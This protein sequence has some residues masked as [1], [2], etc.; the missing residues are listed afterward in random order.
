LWLCVVLLV[1][2]RAVLAQQT[3]SLSGIVTAT[4]GSVLPGVTVEAR[5]DVLPTPRVTVTG[6]QGE[7]RLPALPPGLYTLDFTLSG[8][9]KSSRQAQVQLGINTVIDTTLGVAGVSEQVTVTAETSLVNRTAPT[10]QNALTSAQFRQMPVGQEY[11][12]LIKM[13]P[14]VQYTEDLVR[15]PSA[16]GSGQDNVYQFDGANVTLPLFGTL[17]AEPSSHDIAQITSTQGGARA[18]NFDRAGG[19]SVDSVSKSGTNRYTGQIGIQFQNEAMSASL[20]SGIASRFEQ[21]RSWTDMSFGGPLI[22]DN[23]FFYASYYRPTSNRNDRTN[24][25]GPLPDYD[26]S[27]N[28]G[29]VKFTLTPRSDT[30]INFSYRGSDRDDNTNERFDSNVGPETGSRTEVGLRIVTL[31]GSWVANARSFA[32]FKYSH[33][34]NDNFSEPAFLATQTSSSTIGTQLDVNNLDTVGQLT[35]PQPVANNA[36]YNAFVQPFIDRYG[37]LTNGVPTG[38]GKVGYGTQFDRDDFFRD[39]IQFG[40]NYTLG[41]TISHELHAGYQWYEDSEDLERTSNGWGTITIPGGR[42]SAIAGTGQSPFF[43]TR[44]LRITPGVSPN[45]HS[46][47]R[48]QSIELND[49]IRYGNWTFNAG[50]LFSKDTLYGQGLAEDPTK[51]LTGLV[52]SPGTRYKMYE[53]GWGKM[54]QPRLGATWAYNGSDTAF[55][56]YAR[57]NP[58]ANS[59]PRAASWDRNFN[60]LFVDAH[61][62]ANGRLFATETVNSSTGK[63]FVEDLDPRQVDEFL[64]GTSR[65]ITERITGRL[66]YRHRRASNFWEDTNNTARTAFN[67]PPDIPRELYIPDL[68]ARNAEIGSGGSY[69]IAELDGAYTRYNEVTMEAEWRTGQTYLRGS[70]T[71]SHYYGNFDQDGA[72]TNNDMNTFIGSSNIADGAGRQLWDMKDGDLHGDRPHMFKLYGYRALPWSA[73]AGTYIVAQSGQPWEAWNYEIYRPLVGSST[74]DTIRYAEPAGTRRTPSHVQM[75]LNYTQ[76]VH[77]RTRLTFQ[78]IADVFNIFNKQTGYNFQP[79]VHDSAFNTP[80]SYFNPRRMQVAFRL[81][82]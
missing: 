54:I 11:R 3:G 10:I 20:D 14:A 58:A 33:F 68:A 59:L 69:V 25:Y 17:S 2:A 34:G 4:D 36:A 80:R 39:E 32:T 35:V 23:L 19:F 65:Q 79:S 15:G 46:E 57:Y 18:I 43:T 21:D 73:T 9:Q 24:L 77:F 51:P 67:P 61:F 53:I 62:D 63:L 74:S 76:N 30:L 8:M 56:S 50:V 27:R 66:Y 70:Y 82:F 78:I 55:A 22:R 13:L 28:E 1:P 37:Y 72:A 64:L 44:F 41:S 45:V 52:T 38:G 7:Y 5:S 71:W 12:D 26:N 16:G 29:F 75:D 42:G 60:N 6:P 47:Y 49:T 40:Y 81:L 48:S 31:E